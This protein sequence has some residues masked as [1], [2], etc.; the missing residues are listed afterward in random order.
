MPYRVRVS[1]QKEDT[2]QVEI[3]RTGAVEIHSDRLKELIHKTDKS[4]IPLLHPQHQRGLPPVPHQ[5][6]RHIQHHHGDRLRPLLAA[7]AQG[8]PDVATVI[9]F[10]FLK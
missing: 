7:A 4:N 10:F 6:Q 5:G 3:K 2:S 1:A 9:L 8:E